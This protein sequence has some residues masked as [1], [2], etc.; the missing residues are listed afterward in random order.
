MKILFVTPPPYLPNMLHRIRS[1]DL[2]K[3]LAKKHE[4]HLLAVITKKKVPKEFAEIKKL[5]KS[6]HVIQIPLLQ[7][8]YN[9]LRYPLLPSEVA[10]CYSGEAKKAVQKIILEQQIELLYVKRLRSA[11][12]VPPVLIPTVLDT[13]DAMSAFYSRLTSHYPLPIKLFYRLESLRYKQFEKNIAKKIDHWIVCSP[14]DKAY[15][16]S[17]KSE[18]KIH[19]VPNAVDTKYFSPQKSVSKKRSLLFLGLMDKA[20]NIDAASFFTR[21]ILPIVRQKIPDISLFIVGPRPHHSIQKLANEK[22]I[23]VTG[24]VEGIQKI[25]QEAFVSICPIRIGAGTRNKVLQAWACGVPVVSTTIGAEGLLS[26]DGENILIADT[27]RQFAKKIILLFENKRL[28]AKLAKNGRKTVEKN[29]SFH[30][31]NKK[32]EYVVQY[33]IRFKK[34]NKKEVFIPRSSRPSLRGAG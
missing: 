5:C 13:T 33:A 12:F 28:Y 3:I 19:I 2:I 18:A 34:P 7:A 4:V 10:Y 1:F 24:Y 6:F 27:P 31:I 9:C 17:A 14:I 8:I 32:L 16:E 30:A 21:D 29:Y 15:L 23:F 20:V 26:R 25:F 22:G 11:I